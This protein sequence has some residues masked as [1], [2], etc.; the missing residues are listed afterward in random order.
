[1]TDRKQER[2]PGRKPKIKNL[3]EPVH[4]L[5]AEQAEGAQGGGLLFSEEAV[6]V[7]RA[8]GGA[9]SVTGPSIPAFD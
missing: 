1:M 5:A 8:R 7:S 4:E 9:L 3:P 2:K 6:T